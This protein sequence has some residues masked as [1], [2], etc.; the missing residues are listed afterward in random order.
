MSV[1]PA[2]TISESEAGALHI[3][4]SAVVLGAARLGEGS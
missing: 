3:A 1:G 4:T 2:N